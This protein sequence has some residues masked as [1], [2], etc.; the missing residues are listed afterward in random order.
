MNDTFCIIIFCVWIFSIICALNTW[1]NNRQR[2]QITVD[3]E[4]FQYTHHVDIS[5][6]SKTLYFIDENNTEHFMT[7]YRIELKRIKL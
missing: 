3:G 4:T 7:Y 1:L 2:Y 6:W 5:R